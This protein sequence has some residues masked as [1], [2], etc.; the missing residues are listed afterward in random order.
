VQAFNFVR[1]SDGLI[2]RFERE[3][4]DVNG[5][6][7]YR[8]TDGV[9]ACV[10]LVGEGWCVVDNDGQPNG[11]PVDD[12]SAGSITPP[13]TRWRSAKAGRSYLYELRPA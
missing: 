13:V 10:W 9:V 3:A 5:R 12:S 1:Q 8:R 7:A 11:W 2:Y 6:P 4:A